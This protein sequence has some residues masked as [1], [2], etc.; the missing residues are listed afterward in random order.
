MIT[1]FRIFPSELNLNGD[2]ENANVLSKRLEWAAVDH[3]LLDVDSLEEIAACLQKIELEPKRCIVVIGHGSLAAI[4]S[5]SSKKSAMQKLYNRMVELETPG[6]VVSSGLELVGRESGTSSRSSRPY[7]LDLA[8]PGWPAKAIGYFNSQADAS[9]LSVESNV[10]RTYL[11][12]PFLAR[13]PDW[14]SELLRRAGA[15]LVDSA[16]EEIASGHLEK[17]WEMPDD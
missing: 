9:M 17:I 7:K 5:L 4:A 6:I 13:N 10:I 14:A 16:Q 3:R 2:A 11:H 1:I 15:K 8:L 12:G